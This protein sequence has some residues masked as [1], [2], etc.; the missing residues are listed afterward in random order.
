MLRLYVFCSKLERHLHGLA[1]EFKTWN[2]PTELTLQSRTWRSPDHTRKRRQTE[3]MDNGSGSNGGRRGGGKNGP[4][5]AGELF[6][7][8]LC[9]DITKW[10]EEVAEDRREGKIVSDGLQFEGR[11]IAPLS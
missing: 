9:T 1:L 11:A 2:T 8:D 10:C 7:G 4:V 3:S 6:D 5:E